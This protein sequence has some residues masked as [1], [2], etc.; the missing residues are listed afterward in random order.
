MMNSTVAIEL[1]KFADRLENANDFSAELN[2]MLS[3]TVRDHKR[4]IW[5]GNIIGLILCSI[6]LN[7]LF[8]IRGMSLRCILLFVVFS[9]ITEPLLRYLML[10][11]KTIRNAYLKR[12]HRESEMLE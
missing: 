4:I 3:E 7:N 6:L 8:S 11:T 12:K 2:K 9:I 1:K 5:G 10:L